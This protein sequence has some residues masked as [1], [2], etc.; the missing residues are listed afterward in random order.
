ELEQFGHHRAQLVGHLAARPD[1]HR[2]I[3][4]DVHG[5]CPRLDVRLMAASYGEGVVEDLIRLRKSAFDITFAEADRRLQVRKARI[6][7]RTA[8]VRGP[9]RMQHRGLRIEGLL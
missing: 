6:W 1:A 4:L 9:I 5:A 8:L 2:P 7:L 3:R